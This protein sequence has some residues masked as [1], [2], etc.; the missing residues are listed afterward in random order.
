M[1]LLVICISSSKNYV[2]SFNPAFDLG[3]FIITNFCVLFLE[4][5]IRSGH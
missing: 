4:F 3:V 5:F 2:H 1:S